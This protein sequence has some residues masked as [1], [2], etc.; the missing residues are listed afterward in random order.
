MAR[1]DCTMLQ[2]SPPSSY[3][4]RLTSDSTCYNSPRSGS[5]HA[6]PCVTSKLQAAASAA[7][8]M[9]ML[10]TVVPPPHTIECLLPPP[11]MI[12]C[13]LL[14][15][16]R[17]TIVGEL[18]WYGMIPWLEFHTTSNRRILDPADRSA[19][20]FPPG[21]PGNTSTRLRG[22]KQFVSPLGILLREIART[23][24]NVI[25][26]G[27]DEGV[28]SA[29]TCRDT[30]RPKNTPKSTPRSARCEVPRTQPAAM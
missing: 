14:S 28:R 13:F 7:A 8:T 5:H 30:P 12:Q 25:E 9:S 27:R 23:R 21:W 11:H 1:Y 24:R 26:P 3:S 22:Q 15:L 10:T 2:S 6:A 20:E 18:P 16:S 17:F 19:F 4:C 29:S